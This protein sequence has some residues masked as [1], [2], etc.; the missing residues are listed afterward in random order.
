MKSLVDFGASG[1][2][3]DYI[4]TG[5]FTHED[6]DDITHLVLQ[7]M[8]SAATA[9]TL[10]PEITMTDFIDK[11]KNWRESTY[12]N[13]KQHLGHYLALVKPHGIEDPD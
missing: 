4:L 3:S 2:T 9:K 6:L 8:K 1:E 7:Q 12:T 11:L 13:P 5:D 10:S